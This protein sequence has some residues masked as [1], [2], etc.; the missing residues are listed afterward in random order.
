[1]LSREDKKDV[2]STFGKKVAGAVAKAT[3][4]SKNKALHAKTA[5]KEYKKGTTKGDLL[6]HKRENLRLRLGR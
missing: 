4:D 3:N 2:S 6:A 5:G 1:M